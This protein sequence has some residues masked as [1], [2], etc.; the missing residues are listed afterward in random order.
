M[1]KGRYNIKGIKDFL[2]AAVFCGFLCLWSIRDA[3]FPSA[4][5][6]KKHPHE[7]PVA[8]QVH[9][10]VKEVFVTPGDSIQAKTLLAS[11][12]DDHHRAKV[13]EAEAAF[14]AA[15]VAKD[16]D[17]E[18]KLNLLLDARKELDA[19]KVYNTDVIWKSTHGEEPLFG[20]VTRVLAS[21]ST[22]LQAGDPVMMMRPK[23][24]FY[25][26]NKTLAVLTFIGMIAA[27]FAHRVA[28]R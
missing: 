27:L 7:I 9:G 4:A 3:F 26:F 18:E 1:A 20:E 15:K 10:I 24:S 23:D 12:Y 14:E 22:E 21:P 8:F 25:A 28:S 16:P 17:V 11:L 5:T 19:C 2:I 6:L 13:T